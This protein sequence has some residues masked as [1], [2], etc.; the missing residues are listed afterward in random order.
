LSRG[1]D[2]FVQKLG[3]SP[4]WFYLSIKLLFV[5]GAGSFPRRGNRFYLSIKLLLVKGAVKSR[6]AVYRF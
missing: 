3:E 4:K 6:E 5:K 1:N 2:K